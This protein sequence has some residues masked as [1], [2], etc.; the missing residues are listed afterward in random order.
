M[1]SIQKLAR[2]IGRIDRR[3]TNL[4]T[5]PQL[6]HSSIENGAVDA[7]DDEGNLVM[8][9]GTQFDGTH[10]A[11]SLNGPPPPTP[12][13][14][15][16]LSGQLSLTVRWDGFF[17]DAE[18]LPDPLSF[19][20]TDFSR[21]EVHVDT[22]AGFK[23]DTALTLR[24]TIETPRG[25]DVVISPMEVKPYFIKL[26]ARSLSGNYSLESPEVTGT[27][28]GAFDQVA[29]DAEMQELHQTIQEVR[30]E[31]ITNERF[32]PDSLSVWPFIQGAIPSN[33]F[34]PGA[35]GPS[36]IADFSLVAKKF[37]TNRHILY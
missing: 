13:A 26:V 7:Y 20:P 21:V 16:V 2:E 12:T 14:P 19:A 5:T 8:S 37:N 4:S 22:Q 10:T 24:G 35:I 9:V 31:P 23:A 1:D 17:L 28:D 29:F 27:P 18:G 3:L 33:A 15:A 25:A 32:D 34:A 6:A 11:A 36:D 30:T